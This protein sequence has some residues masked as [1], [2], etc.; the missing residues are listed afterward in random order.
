MAVKFVSGNPDPKMAFKKK[1][2]Q[3]QDFCRKEK[4]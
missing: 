4:P 1:T 2:V 3:V